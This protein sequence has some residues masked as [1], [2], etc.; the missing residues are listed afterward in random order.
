MGYGLSRNTFHFV[1]VPGMPAAQFGS[2]MRIAFSNS[3]GVRNSGVWATLHHGPK[4]PGSHEKQ[5][6][7]AK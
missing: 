7:T 4:E 6:G 1:E 5:I 2:W 3:N